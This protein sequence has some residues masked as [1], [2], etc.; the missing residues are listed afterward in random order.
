MLLA[1]VDQRLV[2]PLERRA[3]VDGGV[4]EADLLE[5]VH[6]EVRRRPSLRAARAAEGGRC[7]GPSRRRGRARARRQL[8]RRSRRIGGASQRRSGRDDQTGGAQRGAL[9]EVTAVERSVACDVVF[10]SHDGLLKCGLMIH[11]LLD[12]GWWL[13]GGG[14]N[15]ESAWTMNNHQPLTT[16]HQPDSPCYHPPA[17]C[18]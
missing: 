3:R 4:L 18:V 10:I 17:R 5:H 11:A 6:H 8:D 14:S 1:V 9:E 12:G 13:V 7:S 15:R 2:Q 16:D